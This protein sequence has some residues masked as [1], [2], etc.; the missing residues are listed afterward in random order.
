ML[1]NLAKNIE[2]L[3]VS[4]SKLAHVVSMVILFLMMLLTFS[5]VMGRYFVVPIMGTYELTELGLALMVFFSLGMTQIHKEHTAIGLLV[6]RFSLRT[7]ALI[8]TVI[9]LISLILILVT[10]WQLL[11]YAGI[12]KAGNYETGDL[13]LPVY[14]FVMVG[15]VGLLIYS[16]TLLVGLFKS[17]HRMVTKNES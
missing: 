16:L 2:K 1:L 4:L 5:D 3:V 6:D 12:L 15:A 17:L 10:T 14:I 8:D 9:Y 11:Q 7:Q 13:R